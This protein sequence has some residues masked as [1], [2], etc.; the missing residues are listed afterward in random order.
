MPRTI[1]V[2]VNG[3][4]IDK[5]NSVGGVQGEGNVTTLHLVFD[6]S[7]VGFGKRIIWRN[8]Q[9]EDPVAVILTHDPEQMIQADYDQL[10]FDTLIPTE[11]LK[12]P[13]WCT[14]T[15]EGY[16]DAD[17]KAVALTV[18]DSLKVIVNDSFYTPGEPTPGQAAQIMGALENILPQVSAYTKEAKS[19]AVGG[20]GTRLGEDTDNSKYYSEQSNL[21]RLKIENMTVSAKELPYGNNPTVEKTV[22][23]Y[24]RMINLEFGIPEG[25]IG[26]EGPRGIQG[27]RGEQGLQGPPGTP[28][29][30]G[31]SG[32]QGPQGIKGE[33]GDIG[34]AGPEGPQGQQGI[35]GPQ[36]LQGPPGATGPQGPKGETG[37]KGDR[38]IDGVAVAADGQYAFNVNSEGHLIVSYTGT[39][40]PKFRIAPD[41]HLKLEV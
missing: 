18:S 5:D 9:G 24:T 15:I 19:W 27:P 7:W 1:N 20:T 6:N 13:G 35:Q 21:N 22:D 14:F 10:V 28:G 29:E 4:F 30:I 23:D 11:S 16:K 2:M 37:P 40:A 8:A 12:L 41:G 25:P 26:P 33:K 17:P 3:E 38:G 34:P 31:A 32:A 36:G 39:E